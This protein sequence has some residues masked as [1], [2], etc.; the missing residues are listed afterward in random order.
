MVR[1]EQ[2]FRSMELSPTT[3]RLLRPVVP[4]HPNLD[5]APIIRLNLLRKRHV[6]GCIVVRWSHHHAIPSSEKPIIGDPVLS[7]S[8]VDMSE[9]S[10]ST[11][12]PVVINMQW[13][14]FSSSHL[15]LTEFDASLDAESSNPKPE[16]C[17][18]VQM[19]KQIHQLGSRSGGSSI[20]RHHVGGGGGQ[21]KPAL[22]SIA[23]VGTCKHTHG[24]LTLSLS[25]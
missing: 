16:G 4:P 11:S 1:Q 10:L 9:L 14:S 25:G 8:I 2:L 22:Q 5:I 6:W 21:W 3:H 13:G 15:P 23:E 7:F 18:S 20:S 24:H 19:E 17:P 12:L